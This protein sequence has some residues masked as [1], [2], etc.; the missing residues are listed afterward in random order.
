MAKRKSEF[1]LISWLRSERTLPGRV[2]LGIG[3]DCAAV[4]LGP[5]ETCLVT[6]DT[7]VDGVHFRLD[8]H[9]AELVGRKAVTVSLSDVAAMAGR[10]LAVVSAVAVPAE[11]PADL[12]ERV[13]TGIA[14]ACHEFDVDLA[15]GDVVGT[16]GPLTITTTALGGVCPGHMLTRSGAKPGDSI[17]VTGDLGGSILGRHLNF[18][19]RLR[20]AGALAT[21]FSL[22]SMIDV[23][24][25]VSRD[26][27]H[28]LRES[29]GL[30]AE[31]ETAAIPVSAAA[32]QLATQ[33][34]E[35]ALWH[36]LNDGEDFELLFTAAQAEAERIVEEWGDPTPVTVIGRI[37]A[38]P[39]LWLRDSEGRRSPL[40]IEGYEHLRP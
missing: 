4:D 14:G 22:H 37:T 1:E 7:L 26:L 34:E 30:G 36:A 8:E 3:D 5:G 25:G 33:R 13:C 12:T 35:P 10:A 32:R 19:P 16:S 24:D 23:S 31:L 11:C 18:T 6:T 15:G 40:E 39:G 2:R 38:E 28:I 27:S 29:G 9:P 17:L 21:R 20:E